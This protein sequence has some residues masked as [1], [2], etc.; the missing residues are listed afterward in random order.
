MSQVSLISTCALN[1]LAIIREFFPS[2]T[3]HLYQELY[4]DL[5][6]N[7]IAEK[8]R[9]I[10]KTHNLEREELATIINHHWSSIKAWEMENVPPKPSSI[11]DICYKLNLPL[12]YF[13]EYYSI[14]YDNYRDTL[15]NWKTINNYTYADI[16]SMLNISHSALARLLNG[17][18]NLSY[19]M[20]LKL[21]KFKIY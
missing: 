14:Y 11:K 9:K 12:D 5:P 17:K 19:D 18:I 15:R 4:K 21:K 13:H 6:Q 3:I 2:A 20:Y 10:R 7:T 16:I 1:Q 8:I